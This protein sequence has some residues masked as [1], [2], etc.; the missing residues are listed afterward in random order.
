MA[1]N[2]KCTECGRAFVSKKELD[3]HAQKAHVAKKDDK[4][5]SPTNTFPNS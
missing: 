3:A 4:K 2:Y 5:A 1:K